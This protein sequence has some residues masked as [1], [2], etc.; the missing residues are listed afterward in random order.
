MCSNAHS[1]W[2]SSN[3]ELLCPGPQIR[4]FVLNQHPSLRDTLFLLL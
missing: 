3:I 2:A 1:N 4:E